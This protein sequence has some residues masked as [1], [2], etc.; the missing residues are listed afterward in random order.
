MQRASRVDDRALEIRLLRSRDEVHDHLGVGHG[1]EDRAIRF[2][3]TTE[4]GAVDEVSVVRERYRSFARRRNDRLRIA[5]HRSAGG[6][7]PDV[8]DGRIAREPRQSL[9]REDVRDVAHLLLGVDLDRPWCND[10][11]A[12]ARRTAG[13]T[14]ISL[15]MNRIRRNGGDA[16]A[17]LATV[18]QCV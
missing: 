6:R 8:S 16:R 17:L 5:E 1:V 2:E 15:G 11:L 18:L 7:V 9:L 3:L 4:V 12:S 13:F 10:L 14:D